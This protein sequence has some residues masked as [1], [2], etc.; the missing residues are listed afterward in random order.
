MASQPARSA[1]HSPDLT[2]RFPL[3]YVPCCRHLPRRGSRYCG[4]SVCGPAFASFRG[5]LV[6]QQE[7]GL[8][9]AATAAE[10]PP[11]PLPRLRRSLI[12]SPPSVLFRLGPARAVCGGRGAREGGARSPA[13]PVGIWSRPGTSFLAQEGCR[14]QD[15]N[16]R[17]VWG[18]FTCCS[19]VC[20][21]LADHSCQG[22]K[23]DHSYYTT[24]LFT[25]LSLAKSERHVAALD[26]LWSLA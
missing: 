4:S 1:S 22:A 3:T 10:L 11:D 12:P 20:K 9:T 7:F 25:S 21:G 6:S 15:L 14:N 2:P 5:S 17:P 18:F 8:L 16:V 24:S 13:L 23:A 19:Q 26:A